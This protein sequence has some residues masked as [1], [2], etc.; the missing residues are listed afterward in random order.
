MPTRNR[1]ARSIIRLNSFG[2]FAAPS[3][4]NEK[5]PHNCGQQTKQNDVPGLMF[6]RIPNNK[7]L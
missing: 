7:K 1:K 5:R 3:F 6:D 4:P 2:A